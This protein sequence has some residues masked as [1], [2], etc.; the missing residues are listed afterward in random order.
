MTIAGRTI[1]ITGA[2]RGLGRALAI[3]AADH[4]A[5][6]LLL[7]RSSE[8]LALVGQTIAGRVG[9]EPDAYRCDLTDFDSISDAAGKI[10]L[11]HPDLDILVHNG[12]QW[13]GGP[14]EDQS[15]TRIASVVN[16]TVSGTLALTRQLLPLLR[17]RP[18]A[19]IHTVVSMSGLQYA[20]FRGSSLPFRTAKAAQDGFVQGLVE[21]LAGT[22]IRI[23]SIYPGIIDDV[24]PVDPA[25]HAERTAQDRLSTKDVVDAILYA[26]A[27]PPNVALRQIVIERT[28]SEFLT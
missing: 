8:Q 6:T 9:R 24:S 28:K 5:K 12:S 18:R 17:S 16:S 23:T 11:A 7:G 13:T 19:D 25:W 15:D 26:L 4:G 22:E 10:T 3:I 20:R 14:L 27:A 2:G 1:A 21:E